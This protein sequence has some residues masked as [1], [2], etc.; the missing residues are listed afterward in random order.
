[1][2]RV[3][4]EQNRSVLLMRSVCTCGVCEGSR[5]ISKLFSTI[6]N[7]VT[8]KKTPTDADEVLLRPPN[9]IDVCH[10]GAGDCTSVAVC[11]C[12]CVCVLL[13]SFGHR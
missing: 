13:L 11:L 5:G 2:T 3:V 6:R 9:A 12:L 8:K 4:W 10:S 7:L 1:M